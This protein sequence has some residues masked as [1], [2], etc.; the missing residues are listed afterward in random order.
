MGIGI[1]PS[2]SQNCFQDQIQPL[3]D[4]VQKQLQSSIFIPSEFYSFFTDPTGTSRKMKWSC[5]TV[6]FFL[7]LHFN[8]TRQEPLRDAC[9]ASTIIQLPQGEIPR[10]CTAL[11]KGV[12][13][14]CEA[15]QVFVVAEDKRQSDLNTS[16]PSSQS[17]NTNDIAS[18]RCQ[19]IHPILDLKI[20]DRD[21]KHASSM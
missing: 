20:R 14:I 21:M 2:H 9:L 6:P 7:L 15:L 8:F 13:C 11:L 4:S 16:S 19:L 10:L 1:T 18:G 3:I 17:Y 12:S 5:T